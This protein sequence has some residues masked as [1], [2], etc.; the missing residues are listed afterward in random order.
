MLESDCEIDVPGARLSGT[1]CLPAQDGRFPVVL[2]LPGSGPLDRNENF[3]GQRLDTFNVIAR[4]L[5]QAG[6]A[7]LRYDKRGCGNSSG[8]YLTAGYFD[9]VTDAVACFDSLRR[10]ERSLPDR[11]YLLGHSEGSLT[12]L[13]LGLQRLAVAGIIQL[14]PFVE[15]PESLLMRQARHVR[16]ALRNQKGARATLQRLLVTIGIADD[17]VAA[18]RKLIDRVKSGRTSSRDGES[19]Q[20]GLG[21]LREFLQL[22]PRQAYA[23]LRQP[24]LLIAGEKDWQCDP[25]DV[26]QILGLVKA[27]VE[28]H[29]VPNLTHLLRLDEHSHSI[30]RYAELIEKPLDASVLN[31]VS[32]WLARQLAAAA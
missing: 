4:H 9:F 13:H 3:P 11:I 16:D 26:Q 23:Q 19:A 2:M 25:G 5:A 29:V 17:A 32:R 14:C 31:L 12:A 8:Q 18:Q 30:L 10:H 28:A 6:I 27:P 15:D 20:V 1:L 21:W 24:M 7:S 22:E